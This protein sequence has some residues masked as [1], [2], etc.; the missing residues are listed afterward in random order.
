[1]PK[2]KIVMGQAAVDKRD[3]RSV[4]NEAGAMKDDVKRTVRSVKAADCLFRFRPIGKVA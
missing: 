2:A 3:K 4:G 1:M